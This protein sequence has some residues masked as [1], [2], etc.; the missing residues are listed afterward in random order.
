MFTEELSMKRLAFIGMFVMIVLLIVTIFAFPQ[1]AFLLDFS[2][3]NF[4]V[5]HKEAVQIQEARYGSFITHIFPLIATKLGANYEQ[6]LW[7]YNLSF[8]SF[9]TATYGLLYFVFKQ[10]DLCL[11]FLAYH[12]FFVGD[13][14]F[15]SNNE[16]HQGICWA[17]I[18]VG[19]YYYLLQKGNTS[20]LP[21]LLVIAL[22]GLGIMT[23]LLVPIP[24][25]LLLLVKGLMGVN[26]KVTKLSWKEWLL[27]ATVLVS[28]V[29]RYIMSSSGSGYDSG[30]LD[31]LK[32]LKFIS[33]WNSLFTDHATA[34]YSSLMHINVLVLP[35][36]FIGA[37][38]LWQQKNKIYLALYLLCILGYWILI[39]LIYPYPIDRHLHFYME[40]EYMI[41]GIV[42][43]IPLVYF[44][45]QV[46][47]TKLV[48]TLGLLLMLGMTSWKLS[49]SYQYF[50]ARLQ[51]I[52][53]IVNYCDTRNLT[54][55]LVVVDKHISK[56][57]VTMDWGL[58]IET[59]SYSSVHLN[60]AITV[61]MVDSAQFQ[62]LDLG[63]MANTHYI[64]CF[65][66]RNI[67]HLPRRFFQ[68]DTLNHYQVIPA[69]ALLEHL[70]PLPQ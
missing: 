45:S 18:G 29:F 35:F 59:L 43:W 58:P 42:L 57:Y 13:V 37:L 32:H 62:A 12:L 16:V 9:F 67:L 30:K 63:R 56:Q 3:I 65:E 31:S 36:I 6:V 47:W 53:A 7:V 27:P 5:S 15:W 55:V 69:A 61:K 33:V 34:F 54:K 66:N 49:R 24:L 23:H 14:F 50:D 19:Y 52:E 41:M 39:N 10:Y 40:S 51:N 48:P 70:R 60:K 11:L 8:F 46:G 21:Y 20:F 1:R 68:I 17:L 28:L 4:L 64:D 44:T 38:L 25:L 22:V 2:F 26:G